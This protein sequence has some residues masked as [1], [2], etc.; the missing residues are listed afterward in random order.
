M[1]MLAMFAALCLEKVDK[2]PFME[3][4]DE[5]GHYGA[6]EVPCNVEKW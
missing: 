3:E 1:L 4:E 2:T 6:I 5:N